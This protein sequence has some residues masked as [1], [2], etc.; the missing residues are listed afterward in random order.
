MAFA[1]QKGVLKKRYLVPKRVAAS[2]Q[3]AAREQHFHPVVVSGEMIE[4]R[5]QRGSKAA[6]TLSD[7]GSTIPPH[8]SD[9]AAHR[10]R[11]DIKR[12]ADRPRKDQGPQQFSRERPNQEMTEN[13]GRRRR[14]VVA[15]EPNPPLKR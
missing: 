5:R 12:I 1:N 9:D 11:K 10:I 14:T 3:F 13:F 15:P 6:V 7:E 4:S 2:L 8:A